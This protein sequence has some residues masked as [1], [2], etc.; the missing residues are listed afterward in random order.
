MMK[1]NIKITV[2]ERGR[3]IKEIEKI[4]YSKIEESYNIDM[5]KKKNC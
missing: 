4:F 5:K 2:N 1:N 3:M